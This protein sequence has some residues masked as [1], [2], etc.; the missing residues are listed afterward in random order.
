M[1]GAGAAVIVGMLLVAA[2]SLGVYVGENGWTWQGVSLEGPGQMQP[3]AGVPPGQGGPAGPM[4]GAQLP[5]G[6]PDLVGRLRAVADG[7]LSLATRAGPRTALVDQETE[8]R[9]PQGQVLDLA[10]LRP[11]MNVA[12]FGRQEEDGR[13]L[14]AEVVLVLGQERDQGR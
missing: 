5:T 10:A 9:R 7:T 8:V 14:V 4:G 3:P 13:A 11:G 12:V 6:P 2:F 1:I